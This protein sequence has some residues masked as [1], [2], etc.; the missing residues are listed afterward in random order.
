MRLL[1]SDYHVQFVPFMFQLYATN[2]CERAGTLHD[3][4]M[5]SVLCSV[6]YGV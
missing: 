5:A 4:R 3:K 2:V 6:K 1:T